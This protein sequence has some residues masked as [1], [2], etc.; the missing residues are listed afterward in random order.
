MGSVRSNSKIY[1]SRVVL[2]HW[3]SHSGRPW[4]PQKSY[5][6]ASGLGL[7]ASFP[8]VETSEW[9]MTCEAGWWTSRQHHIPGMTSHDSKTF[10]N[11]EKFNVRV[12]AAC[13][14]ERNFVVGIVEVSSKI[15][16]RENLVFFWV[17]QRTQDH[18]LWS[19]Q[20]NDSVLNVEE[21]NH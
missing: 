15:S 1:R 21:C 11:V 7:A 9:W 13:D 2:P 12:D 17:A 16:E 5:S 19:K 3:Y 20:Q 10:I 18:R 6:W 14:L 8:T 4:P